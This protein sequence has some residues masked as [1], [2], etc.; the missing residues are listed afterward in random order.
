MSYFPCLE[1]NYIHGVLNPHESQIPEN[2]RGHLNSEILEKYL[3]I[4]RNQK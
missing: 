2:W 4:K 1:K 3:E